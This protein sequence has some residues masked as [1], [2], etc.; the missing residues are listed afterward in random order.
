MLK[1]LLLVLV[2]GTMV[3]GLAGCATPTSQISTD[4]TVRASV[5]SAGVAVSPAPS[6]TPAFSKHDPDD[7]ASWYR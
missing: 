5:S 2:T 4:T 1:Q 7:H 6:S 3:A